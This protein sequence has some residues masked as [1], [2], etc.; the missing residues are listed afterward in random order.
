MM[1]PENK[2]G[3][4]II[5]SAPSGCGKTTIVEKLLERNGSLK[6]SVSYTTRRPRVGEV[7]GKD[8]F[9]ISEEEFASRKANGEFLESEENFTEKYATGKDQVRNA[10]EKGKDI[11][12][13]IDVKGAAKVME[14]FPDAVSIFIMP[15]SK[16]ALRERLK[17]RATDDDRQLALRLEEAERE[18]ASSGEYRYKVVNSDLDKAVDEVERIINA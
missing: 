7:N 18:M 10:L 9:F 4:V 3:R 8:Y 13:S 15:P 1:V 14:Q 2:K 5:I 12:L 16:E 17:G 6:R 11:V